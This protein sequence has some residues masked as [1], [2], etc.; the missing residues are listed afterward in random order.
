MRFLLRELASSEGLVTFSILP[1]R[2][3]PDFRFAQQPE[4]AKTISVCRTPHRLRVHGYDPIHY[5][6]LL[7]QKIGAPD[8][9]AP[10][11]GWEFKKNGPGDF[12]FQDKSSRAAKTPVCRN[13]G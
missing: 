9:A 3:S 10:L 13:T 5:L 11:Q 12:G 8:Q 2:W 1:K 6:P 4:M 7:E